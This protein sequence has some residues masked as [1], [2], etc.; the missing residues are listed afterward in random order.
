[1]PVRFANIALGNVIGLNVLGLLTFILF[2]FTDGKKQ[3]ST[4]RDY[5]ITSEGHT[6][7]DL[8]MMVK[9][10]AVALI[11]A[12]AGWNYLS[13][14]QSV[15]GTDFYCLFFGFKPIVWSKL[16]YAVHYYIAWIICFAMA[17]VGMNVE[18][19]LPSTGSEAKDT[20]IA[21]G[22]NIV[23]AAG[24]ITFMVFLQNAM[25][26]SCGSGPTAVADWGT[27]ITRIWGMPVGMAIGAGGNTYLYRKTGN[28]WLGAILMGIICANCALL[29]GQIQSFSL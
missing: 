2:V 26:I 20:A 3:K 23:L 4:L 15:F 16:P 14:Q 19:R 27:D 25:Q 29:Y 17:A 11:V 7:L 5:G 6:G 24:T 21:M 28:I 12:L 18:H 10:L 13:I 8:M 22:V 9:A 1:M